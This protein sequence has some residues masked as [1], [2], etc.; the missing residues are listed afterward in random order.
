MDTTNNFFPMDLGA[1]PMQTDTAGLPNE[2]TNAQASGVQPQARTSAFG[3]TVFD[4]GVS[5]IYLSFLRYLM[6]DS[7]SPTPKPALAKVMLW[8]S[9]CPNKRT[10]VRRLL[11]RRDNAYKCLEL[12]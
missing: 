3:Q 8:G 2:M 1:M 7:N 11:K 9:C 12:H 5:L 6:T 10:D 4:M